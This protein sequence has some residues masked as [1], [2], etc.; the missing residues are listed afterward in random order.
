[1]RLR[2]PVCDPASARGLGR[3]LQQGGK[4]ASRGSGWTPAA[5]WA[6]AAFG[7]VAGCGSPEAETFFAYETVPWALSLVDGSEARLTLV[8]T[9]SPVGDLVSVEGTGRLFGEGTFLSGT[10]TVH[11]L[12]S[13]GEALDA[14]NQ[15]ASVALPFTPA[16]SG[17]ELFVNPSF[18]VPLRAGTGTLL[19][20]FRYDGNPLDAAGFLDVTAETTEP[21]TVLTIEDPG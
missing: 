9:L 1:M 10:L 17:G 11:E 6:V 4:M 2:G 21:G 7:W 15:L 13:E 16:D 18:P 3:A 20:G 5:G 8:Y 19:L 12:T 14:S